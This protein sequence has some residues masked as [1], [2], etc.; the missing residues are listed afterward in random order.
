[1]TFFTRLLRYTAALLGLAMLP[2]AC[3]ST[4]TADENVPLTQAQIDA[5]Q[6]AA[7]L[8]SALQTPAQDGSFSSAL[9]PIY[10]GSYSDGAGNGFAYQARSTSSGF[11]TVAGLLP[12]TDPGA[13]PPTGSA[14][15]SGPWQVLEIGKQNQN[16]RDFGETE[17]TS[18]R[19]TLQVDFDFGTLL[20]SSGDLSI[21]GR[22]ADQTLGGTATFKNAVV[23]LSGKI[24]NA[25]AVGVFHG[26]DQTTAFAGGFL[27]KR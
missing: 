19:I 4:D 10:T 13:L 3:A 11:E 20:G 9:T 18:G 22:F 6:A 27:A 1:M 21:A 8:V 23:P 12:Q 5:Q 15:F 17:L 2:A 25:R 7:T 24:G 16:G 14:A 26:A